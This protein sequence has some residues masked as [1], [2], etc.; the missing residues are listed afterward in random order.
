VVVLTAIHDHSGKLRGFSHIMRDRTET[1]LHEVELETTR[2][3]LEETTLKFRNMAH[4]DS[5]TQLQNRRGFFDEFDAELARCMRHAVPFSLLLL[6][7]DHFKLFNDS[8]G[9]SA[10]DEVLKKVAAILAANV[11]GTDIVGR[12][13]GEEFI[14]L[15]P[16]TEVEG[17]LGVAERLR[18]AIEAG[19]WLERPITVSIGAATLD[20]VAE[21]GLRLIEE[22][23]RSLYAS[24]ASGRNRTTHYLEPAVDE[25]AAV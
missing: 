25:L 19:P 7:V 16:T 3:L 24:K 4:T 14:V 10:G 22:A 9:H 11:R 1:R 23:D 18:E 13:G 5:L 2:A 12:Y 6:D 17:S 21:N 20:L 15:L 8:F